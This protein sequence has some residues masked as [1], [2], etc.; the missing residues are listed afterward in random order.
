M[1]INGVALPLGAKGR[2]DLIPSFFSAWLATVAYPPPYSGAAASETPSSSSSDGS[3]QNAA[4]DP[5]GG[6]SVPGVNEAV[7]S[8]DALLAPGHYNAPG[9]TAINLPTPTD[10]T[11]EVFDPLNWMFDGFLD[12]PSSFPPANSGAPTVGS[13]ECSGFAN[14]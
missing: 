12:F 10:S 8:G 1:E 2:A 3:V 5:N 6:A 13:A 14:S 7:L 9:T 4:T 11:Y